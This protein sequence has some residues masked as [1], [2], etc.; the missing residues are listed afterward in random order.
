MLGRLN[1]QQ[2]GETSSDLFKSDGWIDRIPEEQRRDE[3]IWKCV[4]EIMLYIHVQRWKT[5][6]WGFKPVPGRNTTAASCYWAPAPSGLCSLC[7]TITAMS[8]TLG[9]LEGV[10]RQG[11]QACFVTRPLI[12]DYPIVNRTW[13]YVIYSY[14]SKAISICCCRR[15]T[16]W[17]PRGSG[18]S[19][20]LAESQLWGRGVE[21]AL[22]IANAIALVR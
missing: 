15:A 2:K 16:L 17:P 5:Q 11:A 22:N 12:A 7:L 9:Q 1:K 4:R 14:L 19:V 3:P 21:I 10:F 6:K 8:R 18:C 13:R 20:S